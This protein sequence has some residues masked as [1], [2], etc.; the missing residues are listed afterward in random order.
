MV[1]AAIYFCSYILLPTLPGKPKYSIW[2]S[3]SH[4]HT[5]Y[6]FYPRDDRVYTTTWAY[7]VPEVPNGLKKITD[8]IRRLIADSLCLRNNL[9]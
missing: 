1:K 5:V 8:E 4:S 9:K 7:K 6:A 3:L 2:L